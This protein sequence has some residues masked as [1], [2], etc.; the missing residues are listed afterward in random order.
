M[1]LM[2]VKAAFGA[3]IP[4]AFMPPKPAEYLELQKKMSLNILLTGSNNQFQF[5]KFGI[6]TNFLNPIGFNG[7]TLKT[8]LIS[9]TI[10][11]NL[12]L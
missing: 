11:E 7:L 5:Y 6:F 8:V 12:D 4:R 10:R 3:P 1:V 9:Q 2:D